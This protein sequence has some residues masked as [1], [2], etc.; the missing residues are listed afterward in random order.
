MTWGNPP[1]FIPAKPK[2]GVKITPE[3]LA[4]SG[5]EDGHQMAIFCWAADNL[6][7]YPQLAW[8]YA[9]PNAGE[10]FVAVATKMVATGL[11]KGVPDIF[12]PASI[13]KRDY[14]GFTELFKYGYHGLYIE[15]KIENKRKLKDGGLSK[16]QLLWLPALREAGYY[17]AVCYGWIEARDCIV[18]YLEGKL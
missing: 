17:V 7:K 1:K 12:L 18:N 16:D 6:S 2:D 15:L 10:R 9:I 11:R 14:Q 5:S 3:M 4:K 8:M 13:Q